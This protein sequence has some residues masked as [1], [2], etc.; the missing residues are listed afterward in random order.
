MENAPV[1]RTLA[2]LVLAALPLRAQDSAHRG[3]RLAGSDSGEPLG[4]FIDCGDAACDPDYLRT[5]LSFVSFARDR[6]DAQVHILITTQETANR[7]TAFTVRFIG[8]GQFAGADDSL[9]M[10]ARASDSQD[11]RRTELGRLLK[12]GL[13]RYAN[14]TPLGDRIIVSY[15]PPSERSTPA[16]S[17]RDRWNLWTFA[18]TASGFFDGEESLRGTSFAGSFSANRTSDRWKLETSVQTRYSSSRLD[19]G[20]AGTFTTIQ[21]NHAFNGLLVRSIDGHWSG[22]ARATVTSSTF[23][24]Q[25]LTTRLA[26]AVEYDVFRYD[27]ATRRQLTLQYSLGATTAEYIEETIFGKTRE[28]LLDQRLMTSVQLRQPWGSVSTA[29]EASYY[30]HDPRRRRGIAVTNV[31]VNVSRGLSV[32]TFGGL[33]FVRDQLFLPK[34]GASTDEVLLRQRQLA[35]S[36]RYWMSLGLSYS[37]GSRFANIVNPRFKGSSAGTSIIQ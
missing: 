22:G 2:L 12:R 16:R 17:T 29:L 27:E 33:E 1:R 32:V 3:T 11:R 15:V 13:V 35:T 9:R 34:R 24:N 28:T 18:T 8:K 26:P 10:V 7:G 4:V 23:L 21:R 19:A 30:L 37:F 6:R 5:E 14:Q 20:D 36:F 25:A 31:D